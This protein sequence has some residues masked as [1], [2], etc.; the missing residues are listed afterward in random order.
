M[1]E[2]SEKKRRRLAS[3]VSLFEAVFPALPAFARPH[4]RVKLTTMRHSSPTPTTTLTLASAVGAA[5]PA[6]ALL[7]AA[8]A[9]ALTGPHTAATHTL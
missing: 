2:K 9:T 7:G 6:A 3:V 8:A 4:T 1:C 5:V